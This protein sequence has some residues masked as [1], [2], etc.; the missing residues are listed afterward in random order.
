MMLL[1]FPVA[2]ARR[3]AYRRAYRRAHRPLTGPFARLLG[4]LLLATLCL[5]APGASRALI[6]GAELRADE[7]RPAAADAS[8]ADLLDADCLLYVELTDPPALVQR[9]QNHPLGARIAAHETLGPV[10]SSPEVTKLRLG[11]GF[12]ELGLATPW[13][14]LVDQLTAGGVHLAID[15]RTK[16]PSLLLRGRDSQSLTQLRERALKLMRDEARRKG[17]PDPAAEAAH[18]GVATYRLNGQSAAQCGPWL[19]ASPSPEAVHALIDAWLDGLPK[20]LAKDARF[21]EARSDRPAGAPAWACLRLDRLRESG[22]VPAPGRAAESNPVLELLGGGVLENLQQTP[23]VTAAWTL[24]DAGSRLTFQSPHDRARLP[25][26]RQFYFGPAGTS[27]APAALQVPDQLGYLRAWRDVGAMWA[28]APD[29]FDEPVNGQLALANGNLSTILGGKDF[30]QDVLQALGGELQLVAAKPRFEPAAP[31][32]AIRLPAFGAVVQLRNPDE[33]RRLWKVMFQTLIGFVNIGGGMQGLPLLELET[34]KVDDVAY[35]VGRY[36]PPEKP[37][38][39]EAVGVHFNFSPTLAVVDDR[40]VVASTR[41]LAT[42]MV[43]ALRGRP[44]AAD[45][46]RPANPAAPAAPAADGLTVNT[47]LR[48]VGSL[49]RTILEDN[50]RQLVSQNMLDKGHDQAAAEAEVGVLF[51]LVE[52]VRGAGLRLSHDERRLRLDVDLQFAV[53]PTAQEAGR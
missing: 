20:P 31:V 45:P 9:L 52:L 17:A 22:L 18:R 34:E 48:L 15:A 16:Q 37:A 46:A 26:A 21:V 24:D 13:P 4:T 41:L 32:P 3:G 6:G 23:Y 29:L 8:A 7:P 25:A 44:A 49:L 2:P 10:L 35:I 14:R 53:E 1:N 43:G 5:A 11:V 39:D 47:E 42:D 36:A 30:S 19:F 27:P 38:E 51:A 12:V 33:T 40:V 50:R 28:A